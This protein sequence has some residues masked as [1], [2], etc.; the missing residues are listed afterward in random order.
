MMVARKVILREVIQD[1]GILSNVVQAA[2]AGISERDEIIV[3]LNPDDYSNVIAKRDEHFRKE[4][5]SDRLQFRADPAVQ[6][7]SCRVDTEM[8][9]IDASFDSQLDEIFRRLQEERSMSS[10]DGA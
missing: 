10:G 3:H 1:R 2:I 7:G 8:G 5:F 6:L 9:T 4:S